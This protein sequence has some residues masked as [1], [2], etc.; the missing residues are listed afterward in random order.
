MPGLMAG[1]AGAAVRELVAGTIGKGIDAGTTISVERT[2]AGVATNKV[3]RETARDVTVATLKTEQRA[4]E[5]AGILADGDRGDKRTAWMRPVGFA[6]VLFYVVCFV[7]Q[8][9]IPKL[10]AMLWLEVKELP[11]PWNWIFVIVFCSIFGIRSIEKW[12]NANA[13]TKAHA[14]AAEGQRPRLPI[15]TGFFGGTGNRNRRD[16]A[17]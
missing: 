15:T 4:E 10:A 7:L 14:V 12:L 9:T 6:V 1:L 8:N 3:D 2:R 16:D 17:Q 11:Y 5:R 13:A